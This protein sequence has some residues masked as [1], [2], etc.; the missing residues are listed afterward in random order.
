MNWECF[1]YLDHIRKDLSV[2]IIFELRVKK[3]ATQRCS[4]RAVWAEAIELDQG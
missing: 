1:G 3:S 2:E 4:N